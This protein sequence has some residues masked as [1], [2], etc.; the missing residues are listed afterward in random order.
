MFHI[1]S[2]HCTMEKFGCLITKSHT[3]LIIF[4]SEILLM[5]LVLQG[6]DIPVSN[7]ICDIMKK[8][9][10]AGRGG[11]NSGIMKILFEGFN[12]MSK[13]VFEI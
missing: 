11:R 2:L 5:N 1:S 4:I 9:E 10:L 3:H 8:R 7:L 13:A 6:S 12:C